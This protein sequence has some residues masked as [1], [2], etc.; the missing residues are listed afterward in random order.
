MTVNLVI[1]RKEPANLGTGPRGSCRSLSA[2]RLAPQIT[3]PRGAPAGA[4]ISSQEARDAYAKELKRA[5]ISP[6]SVSDALKSLIDAQVLTK[7]TGSS[8]GYAVSDPLFERWL[9]R[10]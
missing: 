7:P 9:E 6:G 1:C 8:G 3:H 5:S 2:P 4:E 10:L